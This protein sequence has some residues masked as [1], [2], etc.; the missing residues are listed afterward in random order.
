[1]KF[2]LIWLYICFLFEE[3][4]VTSGGTTAGGAAGWAGW[5]V[6]GMSSLTTKFYQKATKKPAA[7]VTSNPASEPA[8]SARPEADAAVAQHEPEFKEVEK[9]KEEEEEEE[10][11]QSAGWAEDWGDMEVSIKI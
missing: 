2:E 9:E 5:A 6:T 8:S 3:R 4:E 1:M 10:E 7:P 11:D